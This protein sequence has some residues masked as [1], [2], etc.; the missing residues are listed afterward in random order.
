VKK[1]FKTREE[2]S[3]FMQS[4]P[5]HVSCHAHYQTTVYYGTTDAHELAPVKLLTPEERLSMLRCARID[6]ALLIL[7]EALRHLNG[8]DVH[9]GYECYNNQF[10]CFSRFQLDKAP[11]INLESL[12]GKSCVQQYISFFSKITTPDLEQLKTELDK[13]NKYWMQRRLRMKAAF[14]KEFDGPGV[15]FWL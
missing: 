10:I 11:I 2:A 4:L 14:V 8:I 6:G 3:S 7:D 13:C 5:K 9:P 1:E 15:E 12:L